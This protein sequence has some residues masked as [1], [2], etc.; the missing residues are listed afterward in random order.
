[1]FGTFGFSYVGL[2]FLCCL[3]VPNILFAAN[4]RKDEPKIR[5]NK[6]LVAFERAGQV[7]CTALVLIFEDFN[8]NVIRPWTLWLGAAAVLMV[9]YLICWGRYFLGKRAARDFYRPFLGVPLPLA[10]LPVAAAFLLAVYGKVLWLGIATAI[11]G[12][13]HIGVTA[14]NWR[15]LKSNEKRNAMPNADSFG[16]G[17]LKS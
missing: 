15:K 17:K 5:E 13:G 4:P 10:V 6:A 3:F 8:V 12:I 14:Q 2:I 1:M 16:E 7:S 9:L 11:L